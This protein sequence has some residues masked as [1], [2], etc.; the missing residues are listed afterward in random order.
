MSEVTP[1]FRDKY[2]GLTDLQALVKCIRLL[3]DTHADHKGRAALVFHELEYLRKTLGPQL[4]GE[5]TL[6]KWEGNPFK[7]QQQ[8]DIY[9]RTEGGVSEEMKDWL[10]ENDGGR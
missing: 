9:A 1:D 5:Q 2:K 10:F 8:S 7:L 6:A 4:M 3:Q